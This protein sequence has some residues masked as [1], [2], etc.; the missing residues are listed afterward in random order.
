MINLILEDFY[1]RPDL[2]Q[3]HGKLPVIAIENWQRD[4]SLSVPKDLKLLWST[5]G[6]GDIFE[7]ETILQPQDARDDDLIIPMSNMLR[8]KGLDQQYYVFHVGLGVSVFGKTDTKLHLLNSVD[9]SLAGSF[10]DF[11][12]WY[13][14]TL[15]L[16]Y[17]ERYGLTR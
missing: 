3:W 10:D 15:R 12:E 5:V 6:G 7:S 8:T 17:G 1:L 2:F 14:G 9:L 13:I 16:E 4:H 11:N